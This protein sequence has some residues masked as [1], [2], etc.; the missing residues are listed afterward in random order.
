MT[1]EKSGPRL[2]S[3]V[4]I[5][6][7]AGSGIGAA[8]ARLFARE[9]AIVVATDMDGAAAERIEKEIISEKDEALSAKVDVTSKEEILQTVKQV[10]NQYGRIDILVNSA[11]TGDIGLF[12]DSDEVSWDRVININLKGTMFFTQAVLPAMIEQKYG[13]IINIASIAGVVGAGM[14]VAYSASKGGVI[15][16][17]KALAREVARQGICVNDICPGPTDTPLYSMINT[18]FPGLQEKY[19]RGTAQ[20]RMGKPEELAAAALF[21][22]SDECN[23]ITGHSLVVDGGSSMI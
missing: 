8:T 9:G 18:V 11:G 23:F 22:A 5:I 17:T 4:A 2:K 19:V 21:L 20:R 12:I 13:K 3:R 14:Q 10:L 15:G 7:G 1:A 16:F 6:T